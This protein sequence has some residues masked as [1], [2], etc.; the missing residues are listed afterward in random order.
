MQ[1]GVRFSCQSSTA[2]RGSFRMRRAFSQE[3]HLGE[4]S[5]RVN[6]TPSQLHPAPLR[7]E[8]HPT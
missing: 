3:A 2:A 8:G 5:V 4:P 6:Y 7:Y 1:N